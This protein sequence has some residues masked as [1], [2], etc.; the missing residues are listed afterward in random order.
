MRQFSSQTEFAISAL[1]SCRLRA[2]SSPSAATLLSFSFGWLGNGRL[3]NHSLRAAHFSFSFF[4][5]VSAATLLML[6]GCGSLLVGLGS[7]LAAAAAGLTSIRHGFS[8]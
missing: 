3:R 1:M 7:T 4:T 5:F 8:P 2:S 6:R